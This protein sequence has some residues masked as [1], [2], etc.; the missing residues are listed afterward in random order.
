MDSKLRNEFIDFVEKKYGVTIRAREDE[1]PDIFKELFGF[2]AIQDKLVI[3]LGENKIVAEVNDANLPEIPPE[4]CVY[5]CDKDNVIIQ[6]IC[7]VR[8]SYEYRMETHDFVTDNKSVDCLV[9]SD[10]GN[11]DFTTDYTIDV[12][13]GE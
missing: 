8:P 4:L 3:P 6:D 9:W 2:S 10:P 1:K 5:I 11:E 12:Y 13:E 7:L